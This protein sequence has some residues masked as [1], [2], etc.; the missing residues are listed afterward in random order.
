M[1]QRQNKSSSTQKKKWDS[2]SQIIFINA[3][4]LQIAIK[5]NDIS[6]KWIYKKWQKLG[7]CL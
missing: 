3:I 4:N 7:H 6:R 5:R 2:C 1:H